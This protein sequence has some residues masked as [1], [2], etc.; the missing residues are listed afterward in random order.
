MT[1]QHDELIQKIRDIK[2]LNDKPSQFVIPIRTSEGI[3]IGVLRPIDESLSKLPEVVEKLTQ[4]R[5]MFMQYFLTQFS[6]SE[7]RTAT[8]LEKVVI[9]SDDRILF[10]IYDDGSR[11]VGNFGVCDMKPHEAELDNLIRGEKVSDPMFM[12]FTEIALL[13]WLYF[14]VGV[15]SVVLHVFSDNVRT[16]NL[17]SRAGF[18]ERQRFDLSRIQEGEDIRYLVNSTKG[19][20]VDFQY[21]EMAI[22][23]S[24]F[25]LSNPWAKSLY[26]DQWP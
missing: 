2:G 23:R 25:A 14:G 13:S 8:W 22:D 16:I 9:P 5:R 19:E 26:S 12:Y 24:H 15:N 11:L 1:V 20:P 18:S 6:A 21:I 3:Q 17:H 4:W 7:A 10:L